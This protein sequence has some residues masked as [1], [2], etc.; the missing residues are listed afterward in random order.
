M[1]LAIDKLKSTVADSKA[2]LLDEPIYDD[3]LDTF[4]FCETIKAPEYMDIPIE[5]IV[6]LNRTV[7]FDGATWRENLMEIEGKSKNGEPWTDDIFRYFECEIR[8]QEFGQPGS[9]RNLRVVIR[10]G[11]VEIENGVHRAIAAVCWLAAKEKPFLKSVRVS[12]QSKLRSDY[13]AI[14]REAYANGSVVNVPKTP[15]DYLPC[16]A[17]ERDNSFSIYTNTDNG[18]SISFTKNRSDVS[19]VEWKTV[20][21]RM[22]KN[23][24]DM[25]FDVI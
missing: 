6:A 14:F 17:I 15:C 5:S 19:S 20:P 12:Y 22:L 23:L 1:S 2:H 21:P 24:L 13:A 8:D 11:A 4:Y 7:A 25:R 10:G 9:T 18:I 16:I 3:H